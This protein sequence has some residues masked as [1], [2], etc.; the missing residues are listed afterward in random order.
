MITRLTHGA[1]VALALLVAP[2]DA[3][4]VSGQVAVE[5]RGYFQTP[6]FPRQPRSSASL[7]L[8]PE[9][10]IESASQSLLVTPYAR[11][12]QT[13][14]E[15]THVDIRE[16][17]WQYA[18]RAWELRL[19]VGKVFWGVTESQHLVDVINQI[20]LVENIDGEDR[21]GQPMVN[22]ALNRPWGIVD[23]FLLPGFRTRTFSGPDGRLRFPARIA[24]E[25]TQFESGAEE[26]HVDVAARWSHVLG[27]VDLGVAH[28]HGTGREPSFLIGADA[29]GLDVI[30]PRYDQIDQTSLDLSLVRGAWLWKLELLNRVGQ[31]DRFAAL[32]GGLEYTVAGLFGTGVDLGLLAEYL[33]D[34]RGALALS[35]FEDDL[36]AATRLALNDVAGTELLSGVIVDRKTG[37]SLINLEGSRRI[38]DRWRVSL[39]LRSFVGVPRS[40]FM[41]G[42]SAD[43]HVQLEVTRFF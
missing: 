7:M 18:A 39:E 24:T 16:L 8:Q 41:Y 10:Y 2:A 22:V 9:L 35:P 6:L 15:R 34:E 11:L 26:R 42:F 33:F 17:Q 31:G 28:F 36:F 25:L 1:L 32:T 20:D 13:D 23:L 14:S 21:L 19:G 12:D 27:D 43:D 38:G 5:W 40:D 37:A 3:Q 29:A 4:E 30:V